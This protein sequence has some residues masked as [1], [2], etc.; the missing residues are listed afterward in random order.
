MTVTVD[1]T[2][3]TNRVIPAGLVIAANDVTV[4]G[5]IIEGPTALSFDQAALRVEGE[6]VK[7]LDNLIR[8]TSASDWTQDPINGVKLVGA[9]VQFARNDVNHIAGDGI[10]LYGEGAT[11]IGN[12]VHDFVV[13]DGGAHYDGLHY[14]TPGNDQAMAALIQDNTIE[15]WVLGSVDSGMTAALGLPDLS[16][17]IVV[18]HNLIAGGN[19]ALMGGGPGTTITR[20]LFWTK[21]SDEVGFYGPAAYVGESGDVV[22]TDNAYTDDGSSEGAPLGP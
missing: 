16:P 10:S 3:I 7:I 8:G 21:F 1:G 5:N 17:G 14:P 2:V 18:D 4:Q 6:R 19:Y 11:V 22:W 20:N 15:L 13:R 12:W 9:S